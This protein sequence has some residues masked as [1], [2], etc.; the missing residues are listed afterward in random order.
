MNGF[1]MIWDNL[2]IF[3]QGLQN[4]LVLFLLSAVAAF[5]LA[6]FIAYLLEGHDNYLRRG[7][8]QS[9]DVM[10]M[11]PFLIF[12]YLLYYGLPNLG[13]RLDVWKAGFIALITYHAA[14]FAE[15]LR[16]ARAS[17][18]AGQAEAACAHGFVNSVMYWRILLPQMVMRS[19]PL[20]GNQMVC[21]LKDTAFLSIITLTDLTAAA[22]AV[23]AQY[24]VPLPPFIF[25][26]ALYWVVTLIVEA[27]LR[28]LS[29]YAQARGLVHE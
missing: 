27:I 1:Q 17:L 15:I 7:I 20:F 28:R 2:E 25:V 5:V 10:R 6:C 24:F 22:S 23:Q 26:I 13:L 14:Y 29:K 18:P 16:A 3:T 19:G 21:L 12:L 4:T 9:L 8:R 11:L